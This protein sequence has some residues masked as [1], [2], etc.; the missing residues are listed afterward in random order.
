MSSEDASLPHRPS[1]SLVEGSLAS[2]ETPWRSKEH[3]LSFA[4]V[5]F[6]GC[7]PL[8]P[9]ADRPQVASAPVTPA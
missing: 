1:P 4:D 5:A 9:C 2:L 8:C 3:L 7:F 6:L